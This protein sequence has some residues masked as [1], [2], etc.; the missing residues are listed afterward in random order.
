ELLMPDRHLE[1]KSVGIEVVARYRRQ[2]A[3]RLL[4]AWKRWL[5]RNYSTNWAT[6]DA[7]CGVLIGPLLVMYPALAPQMRGWSRYRNMWVRRASAVSLIPLARRD[8]QLDVVYD[9][10]GTLH[11]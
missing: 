5:A 6:T 1:A 4:P 11:G 9:V 2:F 8:A 10:A 7:I 3:P